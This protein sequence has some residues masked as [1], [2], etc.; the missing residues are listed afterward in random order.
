MDPLSR[1]M[2]LIS[3]DAASIAS[4]SVM[5]RGGSMSISVSPCRRRFTGPSSLNACSINRVFSERTRG[6]VPI[7]REF[8]ERTRGMVPPSAAASSSASS[9]YSSFFS[10]FPP[11]PP[12]SSSKRT[13]TSDTFIASMA[14]FRGTS[15]SSPPEPAPAPASFRGTSDPPSPP[16]ALAGSIC[17][18]G[19][20]LL[21]PF[22]FEDWVRF[23]IKFTP[24]FVTRCVS[25]RLATLCCYV[26]EADLVLLGYIV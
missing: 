3:I 6:M 26:G 13:G 17:S 1:M 23:D 5:S 10:S 7:N 15:D 19:D 14:S 22:A 2:A 24:P 21:S 4:T 11:S 25:C 12:S 16:A 8:L 18:D 9:A 20:R